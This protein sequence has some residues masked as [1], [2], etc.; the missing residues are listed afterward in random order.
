MGWD[1]VGGLLL[2]VPADIRSADDVV[3]SVWTPKEAYAKC[4][5]TDAA[6][7]GPMYNAMILP[8]AEGPMQVAGFTWY[9][10]EANTQN[11]TSAEQYACMFP[12][13]IDAWRAAFAQPTAFFGFVQLSTWCALPPDSLPQMR[14]AQMAALALPN[15]GYATNADHGMGCSIHPAEKQHIGKRLADVA[16][17]IVYKSGVQW[18]SPTYKSAK[19]TAMGVGDHGRSGSGATVALEIAL[20]DVSSRGLYTIY[21]YNY[22]SEGYGSHATQVPTIVD[23]TSTFPSGPAQNTSMETQCAWAALQISG[24][25]A[26]LNATVTV[27]ADSE[28]MVLTADVPAHL[29]PGAGASA[30]SRADGAAVSVVASAYGWGPI[31]MMSV[32]D[33]DTELPVLPWNTS[34]SF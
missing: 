22:Y 1:G 33:T 9:Q 26:W 7:D 30:A 32:Y 2:C 15:V 3:A 12:Q 8:Y 23:C 18:K 25:N 14:E 29:V 28:S 21:P 20:N 27:S 31:P 34:V 11:A 10:G 19:Q 17:G 24:S 4:N 5:R 16:L 6:V 13:M